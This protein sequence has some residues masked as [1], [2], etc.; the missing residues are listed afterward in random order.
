MPK[1][2]L[3]TEEPELETLFA[4]AIAEISSQIEDDE[5]DVDYGFQSGW[6]E[7]ETSDTEADDDLELKATT[8][9]FD[10]IEEYPG[11]EESIERFCLPLFAKADSDY[12]IDHVIDAFTKRPSMSQISAAYLAKFLQVKEVIIAL[13]EFLEDSPLSDWQRMWALAGLAQ[14]PQAQDS[15]VKAAAVILKD[16]F[17]HVGLRGAAAINWPL[18]RTMHVGNLSSQCIRLSRLSFRPRSTIQRDIGQPLRG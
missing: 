14:A 10:S 6:E 11:Q 17:R 8:V 2:A 16:A 7:N 9:L 3:V 12:A 1:A 13:G 5:F 4:A 18:W 15:A